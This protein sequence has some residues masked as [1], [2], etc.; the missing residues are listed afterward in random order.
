MLDNNSY[1]LYIIIFII[2]LHFFYK[3]DIK[4]NILYGS[5]VASIIIYLL[6]QHK[7]EKQEL[8]KKNNEEKKN[9]IEPQ[10]HGNYES[11]NYDDII[12]FVFYVQDLHKYAELNYID[13][14]NQLNDFIISY[15]NAKYG[16]NVGLYYTLAN[17]KRY[18]V[19]NS[20][21]ALL[22]GFSET[23]IMMNKI[24]DG[25]Y[26]INNILQKYLDEL[27]ILHKKQIKENG[28]NEE[29]YLIDKGEKSY[30]YFIDKQFEIY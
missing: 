5:I 1:F 12:N 4:L 13:F 16:N 15:E 8:T 29:T 17:R 14:I 20:F 11:E 27:E 19:L 30:N 2:I 3:Y 21:H 10:I 23:K 24:K 6:A 18:N 25:L 28:L 7:K 22:F 9:I 26:K